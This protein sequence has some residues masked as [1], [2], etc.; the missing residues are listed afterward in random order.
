MLYT[1]G[2][3]KNKDNGAAMMLTIIIIAVLIVFT[4]SLILISYN[5]YASQN[6]NLASDRNAE[7][8]YSLSKAL[9]DELT[10]GN[11]ETNSS[12]WNYLRY[13]IAYKDGDEDCSDWPYYAEGKTGHGEAEAKRYFK[14]N[15]N[16]DIEG[17]PA[18]TSV[19]VYWELPETSVVNGVP[20]YS[21]DKS[22]MGIVLH[23]E[24]TCSTGSQSY[25][26][27]D[28]YQLNAVVDSVTL[29][30]NSASGVVTSYNPIGHEI[31]VNEKWKWNHISRD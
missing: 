30:P 13:N 20:K 2:K 14:M 6:K 22:R 7:A 8:A 27:C 5:L 18:E 12:L 9:E 11:A 24:I 16:N 21:P 25:K 3:K 23:V 17:V 1:G 4:F 19:C 31:E 15:Y 26:I 29:V 10:D 28:I